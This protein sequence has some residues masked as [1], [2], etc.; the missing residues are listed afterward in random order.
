[1]ATSNE[2]VKLAQDI[3]RATTRLQ[4]AKKEADARA[5]FDLE[6]RKA[7]STI[8]NPDEVSGVYDAG[9]MLMTSLNGDVRPITLSDL[10]AFQQNVKNFKKLHQVKK[11]GKPAQFVGG[12][13]AQHVIDLALFIDKKRANDE[14]KTSVPV[15]VKSD[16]LHFITNAGP[17]SDSVRH[18]V[19]VQFLDFDA[20]LASPSI[21]A[22]KTG[23]QIAN[24]RLKFD[25][26]CGRHTF[27]YRYMA[28]IGE[29]NYNRS[30]SGFPK[31]RNPNLHGVACKHVLRT[32][33][34]ILRDPHV[35]KRL[36][37]QLL[38]MRDEQTK[39]LKRQNFKT[40]DV[41]EHGAKQAAKKTANKIRLTPSQAFQQA[42]AKAAA[43]AMAKKAA[44]KARRETTGD[45]RKVAAAQKKALAGIQQ[46]L[47]FGGIT[48]AQYDA[49]A[50][51]LGT[52]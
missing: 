30:E 28:T 32:M 50:A 29:Y 1:M 3:K 35:H 48:Q 46:L 19:H 20:A 41:R 34:N 24:G 9:R 17:D 42:R 36:Y 47:K 7:A 18:H 14:I 6:R 16:V 49:M 21:D 15:A 38:K 31:I 25:C 37:Q 22:R 33:H 5:K 45:A 52:K 11:R 4:G 23:K 8:L 27:W 43:Q 2:R 26:D 10:R 40:E 44:D 39:D 12:I 51:N 13:T